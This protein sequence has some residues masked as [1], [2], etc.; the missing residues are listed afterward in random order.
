[1]RDEI[2]LG[3]VGVAAIAAM[4]VAAFYF[5]GT[6][7]TLLATASGAIGTVIGLVLRGGLERILG[8]RGT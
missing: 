5:T 8:T 7:G 3:I 1:M 2:V 6:N 4:T